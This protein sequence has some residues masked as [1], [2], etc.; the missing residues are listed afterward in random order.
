MM[1][2]V[3]DPLVFEGP[4]LESP[5]CKTP[6]LM[7]VTWASRMLEVDYVYDLVGNIQQVNDPVGTYAFVLAAKRAVSP[8]ISQEIRGLFRSG[9]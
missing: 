6:P 8:D 1:F 3:P 7:A 9:A 4:C 2:W 5:L